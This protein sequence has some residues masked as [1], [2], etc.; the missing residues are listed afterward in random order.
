[1]SQSER[2]LGRFECKYILPVAAREEVLGIAEPHVVLDPN[3]VK[4]HDG[5]VGYEVHSLYYDTPGLH[6][7]SERLLDR[8]IRNRLRVRTYGRPGDRAPVYLENK[9]KFEDQV[10]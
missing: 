7:Y 9:R 3:A 2:D 10:V 1:V 8:R 6:D 5:T 4:L